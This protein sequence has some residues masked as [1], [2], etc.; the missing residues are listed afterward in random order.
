MRLRNLFFSIGMVS[1]LLMGAALFSGCARVASTAERIHSLTPCGMMMGKMMDHGQ[2]D[3]AH[4][5]THQEPEQ[6]TTH[7]M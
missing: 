5:A 3:Q 1:I 7:E 4:D 6:D 2:G